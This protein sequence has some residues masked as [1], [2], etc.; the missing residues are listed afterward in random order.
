MNSEN[1]Y[2]PQSDDIEVTYLETEVIEYSDYP[3]PVALDFNEDV[4][5]PA[6]MIMS[7]SRRLHHQ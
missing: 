5:S 1:M 3:A 7:M 2:I 6:C 4:T